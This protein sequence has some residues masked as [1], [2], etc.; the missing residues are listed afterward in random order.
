VCFSTTAY[1]FY[2][3]LES[4][5]V[6]QI[7]DSISERYAYILQIYEDQ[8]LIDLSDIAKWREITPMDPSIG[9]HFSDANGARVAGNIPHVDGQLGWHVQSGADLGLVTAFTQYRFF[10][11]EV[12]GY[13]LSVGK[14]L[15]E[16]D[17]IGVI[18]LHCLM[19]TTAIS[20]LLAM[21]IACLFARRVHIRVADLSRALD[22]VAAGDLN[23]RLPVT[24][25]G[26]DIDVFA[27]KINASLHRLKN[28]VD[29]MKQVSTDIAHDLKTPL[30]RL[31]ISIEDAAALSRSGKCVGDDLET[32]LDEAR[33][34]NG[35]FDA[36][37]RIAQIEARSRKSQF[38][39]FDLADVLVTAVE[40]YTPVVEEY[41]QTLVAEG[42][43]EKRLPMCGDRDL[44]L[45]L[46]VNLIE[47]A[48]RH[49][50]AGTQIVLSSGTAQ[51]G[52]S[53]WF[54]VAD[55]GPGIPADQHQKV[56]KRLYRLQRSRTTGGTGL[57]LS[58]VKAVADL[59]GA[60]IQLAD[61]QPGLKVILTFEKSTPQ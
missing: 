13:R 52:R 48:V 28:S 27:V 2:Q 11:G 34:I 5:L 38:K 4:R 49:N 37:L 46:I 8:G 10:T 22:R 41:D 53:L 25:A 33:A 12:D 57:G 51:E 3:T 54:E 20:V 6:Q 59:H 18:A 40:V 21:G 43:Q 45:Q 44:I 19:A 60:Q 26:D 7:D 42:I 31:F 23:A 9:F 50:E 32:A 35:T 58:L 55:N 61:N 14:S 47:N 24:V 29:G 30:N 36:L 17:D 1:V 56:F 15:K 39:Y 16:I